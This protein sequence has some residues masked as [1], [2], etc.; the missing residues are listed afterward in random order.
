MGS[1]C[2][3]AFDERWRATR[4]AHCDGHGENWRCQPRMSGCHHF[5]KEKMNRRANAMRRFSRNCREGLMNKRFAV[6]TSVCVALSLSHGGFGSE[7]PD[8]KEISMMAEEWRIAYNSGNASRVTS[9][10]TEDGYYL[11][12][13][14]LARGRK[15]IQAYWHR[16]ICRR[17]PHRRYYATNSFL[18]GRPRLC[19]RNLSRYK[20]WSDG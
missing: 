5:S 18:F 9:L 2:R 15:S 10:Y 17:W 19:R 20:R 8:Q 16:G 13:H 14:I 4:A 12:A 1:M 11:S 3:R 7:T 6:L